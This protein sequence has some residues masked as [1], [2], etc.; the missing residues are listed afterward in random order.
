MKKIRYIFE[1]IIVRLLIGVFR[2]LPVD[3]ASNLGGFLGQNVAKFFVNSKKSI[4]NISL[5]LGNNR[6]DAVRIYNLMWGNLGRNFAEYSHLQEIY[7]T[8]CDLINSTNLASVLSNPDQSAIFF[9]G[10]I[11]NWEVS[12][13]SLRQQNIDVDL[14]YR[15]PNNPYVKDIL[16]KCRSIDGTLKTYPKSAAGMRQVITALKQG[17]KI[18][19]LIDQKYNQGVEVPFFGRPA[20]TSLAF[21]QLAKKFNCPLIPVQVERQNGANFK[22]TIH[23]PMDLSKD[24]NTL[25]LEAHNLLESWILNKPEHWLW[26]HKRW[27]A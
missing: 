4:N 8:R 12:A 2:F 10:H 14:I 1:A 26:L 5:C 11:A 9:S 24:D 21:I 7:T 25:I 27:K 17:R 19:I 22:V 16:D 20:M 18:G 6:N 15:A 23:P 3:M 13:P